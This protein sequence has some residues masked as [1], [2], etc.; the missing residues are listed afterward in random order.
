MAMTPDL[1][2]LKVDAAFVE[3]LLTKK[4]SQNVSVDLSQRNINTQQHLLAALKTAREGND[5]GLT[6]SMVL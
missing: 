1:H 5:S 4:R 6:A 3:K 2:N